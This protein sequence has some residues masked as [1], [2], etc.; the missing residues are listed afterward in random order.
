M[1][2]DAIPTP[3]SLS[4]YSCLRVLKVTRR[5]TTGWICVRTSRSLV[6]MSVI[7][8]ASIQETGKTFP[9]VS[10]VSRCG[11]CHSCLCR[12]R[13]PAWDR[14]HLLPP[15]YTVLRGPHSCSNR[16]DGEISIAYTFIILPSFILSFYGLRKINVLYRSWCHACP[17]V[18]FY[19]LQG[20]KIRALFVTCFH[21][22]FLL[23]LF[24]DRADGGGIFLRNVGWLS[25][26]YTALYSYKH[27]C[28]N[29]ESYMSLFEN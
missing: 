4:S 9:W 7:S 26:D 22:G 19:E 21:S 3:C 16:C 6:C 5:K 29:V 8:S 20:L 14:L 15:S 2:Y 1:S 11:G 18:R 17:T 23:G 12:A 28:E 24:F 13:I 27:R 25:M 10:T